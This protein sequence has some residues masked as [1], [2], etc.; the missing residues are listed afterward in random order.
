MRTPENHRENNKKHPRHSLPQTPAQQNSVSGEEQQLTTASADAPQLKQKAARRPRG[1]YKL[2][3]KPYI[4]SLRISDAEMEA[5]RE[6]MQLTGKGASELM[7]EAYSL[8]RKRL[9]LEFTAK[10]A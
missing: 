7:R 10:A 5:V 2:P 8:F 6:L 1:K 3:H 4:V 9:N